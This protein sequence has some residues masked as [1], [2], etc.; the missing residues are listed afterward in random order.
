MKLSQRVIW[1][2]VSLH[3]VC[4]NVHRNFACARSLSLGILSGYGWEWKGGKLR[5]RKWVSECE[6]EKEWVRAR[7]WM[8]DWQKETEWVVREWPVILIH[9]RN[10]HLQSSI[11]YCHPSF[12]Y[13]HHSPSIASLDALMRA[14]WRRLEA[15]R[16]HVNVKAYA[17]HLSDRY[18]CSRSK[19][20]FQPLWHRSKQLLIR[21]HVVA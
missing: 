1:V 2:S 3:T 18:L 10:H 16:T 11:R 12:T 13:I 4:E 14:G 20:W 7:E 17:H 15:R 9:Y 21:L 8:R 19:I 5:V 6:S